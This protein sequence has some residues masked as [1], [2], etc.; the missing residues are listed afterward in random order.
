MAPDHL[1]AIWRRANSAKKT[2]PQ[3]PVH[4]GV[5]L[6]VILQGRR[7]PTR[8]LC[9]CSKTEPLAT[10]NRATDDIFS[11]LK[12]TRLGVLIRQKLCDLAETVSLYQR[13]RLL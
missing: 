10:E 13:E 11:A 9:R 4:R 2:W 5:V 6:K 12:R 8:V 1:P 7:A 3:N